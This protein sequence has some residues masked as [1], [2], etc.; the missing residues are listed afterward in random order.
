MTTAAEAP[1]VMLAAFSSEKEKKKED[2][3][4]V[5]VCHKV[6]NMGCVSFPS[7]TTRGKNVIRLGA[8]VLC[9]PIGQ[10]QGTDAGDISE[11]VKLDEKAEIKTQQPDASG[12]RCWLCHTIK[13]SLSFT[14][15]KSSKVQVLFFFK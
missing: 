12:T 6:G 13:E 3:G 11:G 2:C 15:F 10:R 4:P 8:A 9:P 14:V 5:R 7:P 1:C